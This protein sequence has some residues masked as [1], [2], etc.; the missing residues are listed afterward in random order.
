MLSLFNTIQKKNNQQISIFSDAKSQSI[1]QSEIPGKLHQSDL[2]KSLKQADKYGHKLSK[3]H[4]PNVADTTVAQSKMGL[5][6]SAQSD[7]S[8]SSQAIQA[9]LKLPWKKNKNIEQPTSN[10]S[11][12]TPTTERPPILQAPIPLMDLSGEIASERPDLLH[13]LP[14]TPQTTAAPTTPPPTPTPQTTAGST[15]PPPT[16]TTPPQQ[17][18]PTP[19]L[20]KPLPTIPPQ[21]VTPSK[22]FL[23]KNAGKASETGD[24][25]ANI[26]STLSDSVEHIS[27]VASGGMGGVLKLGTLASDARGI[28]TS[29]QEGNKVNAGASGTKFLAGGVETGANIA[30][31]GG[32]SVNS[33]GVGLAGGIGST[34]TG[35]VETSEGA[36]N[37]HQSRKGYHN[38]KNVAR[39]A[40]E[41]I[42]PSEPNSKPRTTK[43]LAQVQKTVANE[44]QKQRDILQVAQYAANIQSKTTKREGINMASGVGQTIGGSL[45]IAGTAGAGIGAVPGAV[46]AMT[47][48][49]IKPGAWGVRAGKQWGRDKGLPGFNPEKTSEKKNHERAGIAGKLAEQREDPQMQTIFENLPSVSQDQIA[50]FKDTNKDN[51]MSQSQ[52]S[53]ILKRRHY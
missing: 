33:L 43:E 41:R 53:E 45:A 47:A 16:P 23:K 12:P 9:T 32:H 22:G 37:I 5:N 35:L 46:T 30:K 31:F 36:H 29:I 39:D 19:N 27:Q 1:F 10:L 20:N 17:V 4:L 34:V 44:L 21:Q 8:S 7:N 11:T 24:F 38:I 28:Y 51:Q 25:G 26:S 48:A 15:T 18:S 2:N 13:L 14:P 40:A 49:S 3:K 6:N 42:Q 50:S 52:I